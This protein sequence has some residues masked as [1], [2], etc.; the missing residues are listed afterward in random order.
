M[1][2][3]M[4][5]AEGCGRLPAQGLLANTYVPLQAEN[6]KRYDAPKGL[7]RGTLFP[8][9]DLPYL[10]RGNMKEKHGSALAELQALSFAI[11]ELAL[12]LDT[13]RDDTEA[14]AL[15]RSYSELYQNGVAEYQKRFGILYPLFAAQDGTYQWTNGPWPWEYAANRDMEE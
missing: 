6:P 10:G 13:H 8:G 11:N 15:L 2:K 14:I 1:N 4:K 3:A 7:I 12:Y 5:P 9:L